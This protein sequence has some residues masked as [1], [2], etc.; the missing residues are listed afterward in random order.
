MPKTCSVNSLGGLSQGK[1]DCGRFCWPD[2]DK[3]FHALRRR[4]ESTLQHL[5]S[6]FELTAAPYRETVAPK[7]E[8][9]SDEAK[10]VGGR[11]QS[12]L[13]SDR[14]LDLGNCGT[15]RRLGSKASDFEFLGSGV[16]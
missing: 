16:R 14:Y 7:E 8:K 9:T 10:S 5:E 4:I 13:A 12:P 6:I 1:A 3:H 2:I 11:C 15:Y